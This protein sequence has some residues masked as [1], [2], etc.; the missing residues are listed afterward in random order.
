MSA[1]GPLRGAP[2]RRT[3]RTLQVLMSVAFVVSVIHYIDNT[4]NYADYPQ[5]EPGSALPN[6]SA[7][8]IAAAWFVF[9]AFGVLGLWWWLHGRIRA[10]AAA[11]AAFSGSGLVGVGHYLVP[12]ATDMVWWRQTHVSA[13]II[14]GVLLLAFALWSVIALRGDQAL[15]RVPR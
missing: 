2:P 15:A 6:P 4:L 10:A 13:D 12:G 1:V 5:V 14:C 9:T 7:R 11:I 8:V 3:T